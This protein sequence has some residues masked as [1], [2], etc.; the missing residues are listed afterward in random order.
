MGVK[1][2][3][4]NFQTGGLSLRCSSTQTS[5]IVKQTNTKRKIKR[6]EIQG[7]AACINRDVPEGTLKYTQ[8]LWHTLQCY[9]QAGSV[10]NVRW[11]KTRGTPVPPKHF[12]FL[13]RNPESSSA[14]QARFTSLNLQTGQLGAQN[15]KAHPSMAS[16]K[17]NIHS[18]WSK[19]MLANCEVLRKEL[20]PRLFIRDQGKVKLF[21]SAKKGTEMWKHL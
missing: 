3:D 16:W 11:G 12:G 5:V 15:C 6:D 20:L 7:A 2:D 10:I 1:Y 14:E 9:V 19:E 8:T 17:D 18:W 21:A 4:N 13:W